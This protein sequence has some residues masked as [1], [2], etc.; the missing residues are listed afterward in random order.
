MNRLYMG[1]LPMCKFKKGN[2]ATQI[3]LFHNVFPDGVARTCPEG[4]CGAIPGT[5]KG[6]FLIHVYTFEIF[7][8]FYSISMF[9]TPG[10]KGSRAL[11]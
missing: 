10:R 9:S 3:G 5:Y 2:H 7:D 11:N 1:L 8:A 6:V 4:S